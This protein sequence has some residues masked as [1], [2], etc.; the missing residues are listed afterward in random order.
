MIRKKKYKF[1]KCLDDAYK[2]GLCD[3]TAR[4]GNDNPYRKGTIDHEN[5]EKAFK[6]GTESMN[7]D[8]LRAGRSKINWK[9]RTVRQAYRRSGNRGR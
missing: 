2:A 9:L 1:T 8:A 3:A 5:Y 7:D 4:R 6:R